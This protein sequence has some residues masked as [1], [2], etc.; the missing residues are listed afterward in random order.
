M[1]MGAGSAPPAVDG[2]AADAADRA[3]VV[4]RTADL[5]VRDYYYYLLDSSKPAVAHLFVD[6]ASTAVWC[7]RPL[8]SAAEL[9]RFLALLPPSVHT[10]D[11]IGAVPLDPSSVLISVSGSVAYAAAPPRPFYDTLVLAAHPS[12]PGLRFVQSSAYRLAAPSD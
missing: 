1:W 6:G 5:F 4:R 12:K 10:V 7:G 8:A 2:L 11:S 9:T 3:A